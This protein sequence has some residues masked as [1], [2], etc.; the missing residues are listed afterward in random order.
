MFALAKNNETNETIRKLI[1]QINQHID[2]KFLKEVGL[3]SFKL[4]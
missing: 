2:E 1:P 4:I 3:I